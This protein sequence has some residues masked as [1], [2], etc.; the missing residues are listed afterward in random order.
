MNN[1]NKIRRES[2]L[3]LTCVTTSC[4]QTD[5]WTAFLLP[6]IHLFRKK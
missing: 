4:L 6:M 5:S 2:F 3:E 1:I